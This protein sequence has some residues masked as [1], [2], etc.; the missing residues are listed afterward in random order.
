MS[1]LKELKHTVCLLHN[2]SLWT[3]QTNRQTDLKIEI[4]PSY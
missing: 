4:V 3:R 2:Y 1:F